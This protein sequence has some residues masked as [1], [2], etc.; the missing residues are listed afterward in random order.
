MSTGPE[1]G[2]R[3]SKSGGRGRHDN[4]WLV[5]AVLAVAQFVVV[6]DLT[7]VNV[8]L[9]HIRTDLH[10]S[11]N[12]L[13]W[14]VSAYTLLFGGFLLLGGRAA[15]LLGRHTMFIAGVTLFTS[16]SLVAGV[17]TSSAMMVAARAAQGLGGAMLSPAALSLLAVTF[18]DG[19][20]RSVA[21][22][23]WGA[24][25]GLG[26]I[27]G[28]VIGG[29]LIDTIGWRWVFFVNVPIGIGV[30][31]AAV[32]LIAN[33]RAEGLASR[34]FDALG[35]TLGTAGLL[36]LVFA[37][38]RTQVIGWGS[39]EVIACL[40]AGVILLTA[41]VA[42]EARAASPLVPLRLF[43]T[44]SLRVSTVALALNGAAFLS[45]F[46]LTAIFLQQ[47]RGL[48]ALSAGLALLPMGV[49]AVVAAVTAST[50]VTR[51]GTRAVQMAGSVLSIVGLLLLSQ[52]GADGAYV[53]T[54]L[55]G[56]LVYGMGILSVGVPAQISAIAEVNTRDAGAASGIVTA[57]F[58]V[59]G[60]LGLAVIST[61]AN[62][63]AT[64]VLATGATQHD[65]LTAGF[66]RGLIVAAA[67]AAVNLLVAARAPRV[68]P[69]GDLVAA[70]SVA[71]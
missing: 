62:S 19:R 59:G 61:I 23:V 24:L 25:A 33:S 55:P 29:V 8:A 20:G 40:T 50:L 65:A 2:A 28:V 71:A 34:S 69:D 6:L 48:S 41:F 22:G 36:S 46:F 17:S 37:I 39:V 14:V 60:A 16:A 66:M 53:T 42:V 9:P 4:R 31:L 10:F 32:L 52:A 51:I 5:L 49:A 26:G 3:T 12:G 67:L 15:D 57:G 56:L 70:A 47:V 18:A 7:I 63:R 1:L 11:A 27:I 68:D 35:A 38:V 13:Q 58:Q 43:R 64:H 30:S 44:R 21:L 54:L 45:M